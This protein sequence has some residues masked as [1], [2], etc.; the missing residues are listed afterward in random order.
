MIDLETLGVQQNAAFISIGACQF[1]PE[2]GKI[3]DKFYANIDW[4][5]ALKTRSVTGDTIK[6]W[7]RQSKEAQN[8][9]CAAGEPLRE[10]LVKFARWFRKDNDERKAWGN[11]A[12]FDIA[13][14]DNAYENIFGVTPWK[15]WNTRDV[16]TVVDMAWGI[17]DKN[18][19][20]FE[21]VEHNALDDAIHQAKYVSIMWQKLRR[22]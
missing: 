10:V 13:M 5:D 2:A 8:R 17:V 1:N 12:T 19:V 11:G 15:F 9:V 16:R 22:L 6:W 14:L 7:M 21:G 20:I 18:S 3:G 4:D